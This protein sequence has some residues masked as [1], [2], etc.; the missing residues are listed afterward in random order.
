MLLA[1]CIVK[2]FQLPPIFTNTFSLDLNISPRKLSK[3]IILEYF[4]H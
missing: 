2:V 4:V 1:V 3:K